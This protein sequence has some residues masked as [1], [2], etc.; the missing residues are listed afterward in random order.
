MKIQK[1]VITLFL[2]IL[3]LQVGLSQ[4]F[5]M[6]KDLKLES[7]EDYKKH[8]PN[9]VKCINW[10]ENTPINQNPDKRTDANAYLML[11]ATGT[12]SV[13]IEMQAFQM[14]LTTKNASLLMSFIGGWIKH[15]IENPNDKDNAE[16]GNIAGINSIIKVYKAN[17]G[18]GMKKDRRIEKL[19]KLDESELQDW[20][21]EQLK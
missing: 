17:K 6:P 18:N 3:C 10:L 19:M 13:T 15:V 1:T 12:P 5:E 4:E 11:W 2:S 14:D 20:V 21:A 7:A 16:A 9:V 8:E